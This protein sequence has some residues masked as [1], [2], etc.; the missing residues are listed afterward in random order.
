[1]ERVS[2][3]SSDRTTRLGAAVHSVRAVPPAA[4]ADVSRW[5]ASQDWPLHAHV[6]E[7]RAEHDECQRRSGL[8]PL[9]VL[10]DAGAVDR[11]FTAVH[12]TH[13]SPEDVAAL[14]A[15]GAGC[16]VCPTTE[17]DLGD[18]IGPF[19]ALHQAGATL[20]LGS[21][22]HAVVDGLEEARAIEMDSRLAAEQ[23]GV[24]SAAAL[25]EVATANG[26]RSLGWDAGALTP[27]KLADFVSVRLDSA[28]TAGADPALAATAVFA[29]SAADVSTVVVGGRTVVSDGAHL[30]VPNVAGELSASIAALYQ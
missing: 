28:R 19:P 23:R 27:G 11:R 15:A 21:D 17:R 2:Q 14:A 9:G 4:I 20:S 7:Q 22:S 29:A 26:M 16:C 18:G 5:V 10:A 3:L 8:T 12:G 30:T 1:M 25:L 6:S 13:F 24:L